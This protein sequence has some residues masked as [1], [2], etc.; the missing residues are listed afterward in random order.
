MY[1]YVYIVFFFLFPLGRLGK[2]AVFEFP[3]PMMIVRAK[4]KKKTPALY[5]W[6]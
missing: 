6:I 3:G 1:M 2:I 4:W 5:V